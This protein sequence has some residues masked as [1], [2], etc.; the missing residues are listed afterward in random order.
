M[1]RT[2]LLDTGPL[3][4]CMMTGG[5]K[6]LLRVP[7]SPLLDHVPIGAGWAGAGEDFDGRVACLVTPPQRAL[8]RAEHVPRAIEVVAVRDH[9]RKVDL[10]QGGQDC[11]L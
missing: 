7:C 4:D 10:G 11:L 8:E 5:V 2:I 9:R 1:G 3:D 6:S